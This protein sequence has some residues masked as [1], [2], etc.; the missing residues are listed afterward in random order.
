MLQIAANHGWMRPGNP[1]I[2]GGGEESGILYIY[3]FE[4]LERDAANVLGVSV[5]NHSDPGWC[6]AKWSKH[7]T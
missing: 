1:T 2:D 4:P 5:F 3:K 7:E 6:V